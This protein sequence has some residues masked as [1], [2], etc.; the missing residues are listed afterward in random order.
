[1]YELHIESSV[2][3]RQLAGPESLDSEARLR[4]LLHF[5]GHQLFR[6]GEE[7]FAIAIDINFPLTRDPQSHL[8]N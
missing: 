7:I 1:M 4:D 5:Q 8:V 6:G 3:N 2:R